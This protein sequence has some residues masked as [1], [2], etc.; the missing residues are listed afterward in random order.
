MKGLKVPDGTVL[1]V[2][3]RIFSREK[4]QDQVKKLFLPPEETVHRG[5]VHQRGYPSRD[6]SNQ[7]VSN[8]SPMIGG[9]Q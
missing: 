6:I 2:G 4:G 3:A 8:D 7:F 1:Y 5:K 9:G